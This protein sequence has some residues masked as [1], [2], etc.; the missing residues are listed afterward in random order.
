MPGSVADPVGQRGSVQIDA[1]P[2]VDL[3]LAVQRQVVGIFR[4]QDLGD[5]G[6]RRHAAF[7][8]SRRREGLHDTIFATPATVFRAAGDEHPELGRHNVQPLAFVLADTVQL[9]LA[10]GAGPAVDIDDDLDPWQMRRQ[11]AAVG[12]SL[13]GPRGS[14]SRSRLICYRRI[15]RR[16]LLDV[17]ETEQ[18][19]IF[20]QRL[21][22][23][24]KTVPLHF[25]D[26][27]AQPLTL[28]LLGEQHRFQRLEIVGQC[29][30]WHDRIRSYSAAF[31]DGLDATIHFTAEINDHRQS[32]RLHRCHRFPRLMDA[33]P[34]QPFQQ[35][36]QLRGR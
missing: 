29:V 19:L 32:A 26:D 10:A 20:G 8:Q 2:G 12:A 17:F 25:F 3:R 22:P 7:D 31:C 15:A 4:H 28:A 14:L 5:G 18:H 34:V 36:R 13:L 1:L 27:L 35:R 21:R 11:R 23:A 9:A 33:T 16:R 24:A 6:F 30:A